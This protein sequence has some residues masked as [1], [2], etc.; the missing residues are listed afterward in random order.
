MTEKK[1][2]KTKNN[3]NKTFNQKHKVKVGNIEE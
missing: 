1:V 3:N 2:K